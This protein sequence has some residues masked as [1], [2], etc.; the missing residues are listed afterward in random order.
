VRSDD[1]HAAVEQL[2][3]RTI[4]PGDFVEQGPFEVIL[5]LVGAPNLPHNLNA[6][7]IQGRIVVIGIGAGAKGELNLGLLM[8]KRARIFGSTLRSRPLEEKALA[9]RALERSVLPLFDSGAL[10]VPIAAA[11]ELERAAAAYER[12]D[13]GG[14]FG[15]VVLEMGG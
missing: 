15:K 5:E 2:G 10:E 14:K 3:A 13:A 8:A 12:F 4:G 11:F 9:A 1:L 6:L 7:S